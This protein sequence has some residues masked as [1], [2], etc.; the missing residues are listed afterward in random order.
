M[1]AMAAGYDDDPALT[2]PTTSWC[3]PVAGVSVCLAFL[4]CLSRFKHISLEHR[5][6]YCCGCQAD[7]AK[8]TP[9]DIIID[10][11]YRSEDS[12]AMENGRSSLPPLMIRRTSSA[13]SDGLDGRL[14]RLPPLPLKARGGLPRSSSLRS[15]DSGLDSKDISKDSL[16]DEATGEQF[17]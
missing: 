1:V 15:T 7:R 16:L 6:A 17:Q 8:T 2:N 14:T 10:A 4:A 11:S 3:F 5:L 12:M 9:S 13:T